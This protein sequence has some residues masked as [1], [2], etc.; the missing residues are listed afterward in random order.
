MFIISKYCCQIGAITS[1]SGAV[2]YTVTIINIIKPDLGLH[3]NSARQRHH[4]LPTMKLL[5][6]FDT[7]FLNTALI[8][9]NAI[10]IFKTVRKIKI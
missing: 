4:L 1:V 5:F 9:L 8:I 6:H 7:Q 2:C 3:Y 10:Y